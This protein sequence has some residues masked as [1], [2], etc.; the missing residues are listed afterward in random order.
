MSDWIFTF[1]WGQTHPDTGEPLK[2]CYV[3]IPG[4]FEEA[5]ERMVARFGTKWAFQY[6]SPEE[7]GADRFH[8]RE[9]GLD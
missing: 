5:R 9:I 6:E 1:G 7:A 4:T 2:D 8:L 3:R